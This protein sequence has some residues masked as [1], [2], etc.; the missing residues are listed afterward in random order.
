M[1]IGGG[2][3]KREV[4]ARRSDTIRSLPYQPLAELRYSLSAADAHLVT[5]GDD[6]VGIVH[7]SKVYGALAV[8]RPIVLVGPARCHVAD[9][10]AE[11]EVGW[12]VD[13]GDIEGAVRVC[14]AL[15]AASPEALAA[16]GARARA[17]VATRFSKAALCGRF[18]DLVEA[19]ARS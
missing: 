17:L 3:G 12:R 11:A 4:D 6:I 7:P 10:L 15:L 9:I 1:F 14:R 18:C 16:M 8:G 19:A 2:I 5:V 13:H